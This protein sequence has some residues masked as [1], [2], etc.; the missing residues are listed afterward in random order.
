MRPRAGGWCLISILLAVLLGLGAFSLLGGCA[1]QATELER[2]HDRLMTDVIGPAVTKSIDETS[3]RTATLQG[4][5][6]VIEPGYLTEIE[7][8]WGTGVKAKAIIRVV[9][10]SGQLTGHSQA[11]QGQAA[12]VEPPAIRDETTGPPAS[13]STPTPSG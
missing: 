12:V 1:P 7:G 6:Q 13:E 11:D 9:G 3:V 2:F 8:F 10:V 5:A 4:G